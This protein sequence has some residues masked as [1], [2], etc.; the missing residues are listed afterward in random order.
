MRFEQVA[1]VRSFRW[2]KGGLFHLLWSGS[3]VTD[4]ASRLL[5]SDSV[6]HTEATGRSWGG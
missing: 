4:V 5:G 6:V 2:P 3:L 1:P